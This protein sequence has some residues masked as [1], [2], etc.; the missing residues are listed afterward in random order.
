MI[1]LRTYSHGVEQAGWQRSDWGK[2]RL[3]FKIV[4]FNGIYVFGNWCC[5]IPYFC[6]DV[7]DL[8]KT[9]SFYNTA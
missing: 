6:I 4:G 9:L 7:I 3:I 8:L 1:T 5:V 2:R